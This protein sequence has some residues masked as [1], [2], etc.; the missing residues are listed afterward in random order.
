[1][2]DS[3][4]SSQWSAPSEN[5]ISEELEYSG[6][7]LFGGDAAVKSEQSEP[8]TGFKTVIRQPS[9]QDGQEVEYSAA[10]SSLGTSHIWCG[11]VF[12]LTTKKRILGLGPVWL[13]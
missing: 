6:A 5:P 12:V 1:M 2:A 7:I 8:Y 9:K 11:L 10:R 13:H 4:C 3:N